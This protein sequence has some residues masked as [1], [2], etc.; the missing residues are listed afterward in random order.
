[1]K[2][3]ISGL[4]LLLSV[5]LVCG[6]HSTIDSL[7]Q[8]L[9]EKRPDSMQVFLLCDLSYALQDSRPD[10]ALLVAQK[11]YFIAKNIN[12]IKGEALGLNQMAAAY[13]SLGDFPKSLEYYIAQLKLEEK[14]GHPVRLTNVYMA[15][16]SLYANSME[17]DKALLYAKKADQIIQVNNFE[18]Y[19]LYSLLNIG[20]VYE[21]KNLLDSAILYTHQSY[22]LAVKAGNALI[23]GTALNNLGNIY[24][25]SG[26]D[27][28]ALQNYRA[29]MYYQTSSGNYSTYAESTL[30]IARIYK[31]Q[32][33]LDSAIY[34]ARKSF[35]IAYSNQFLARAMEASGVLAG[36]YKAADKIDSAFEYQEKMIRLKDAV[37]S[38]DKIRELQSISSAE[39][40]R[41]AELEQ[42]KLA[43]IRE[44]E[45][46]LQFLII[47]IAIPI[48]FLLSIFISRRKVHKRLIE[49]TGIVS[50][51]LFFEFI[52][53]LLHPF[54]AEKSHHS[55]LIEIVIFVAIAAIITPAHHK[56]EHWLLKKLAE[57]N[58]L[59]H[60]LPATIAPKE[61][62]EESPEQA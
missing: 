16:S 33:L 52:T 20:D 30:G 50:V 11:A 2:R 29:G 5:L 46:K 1:M 9:Q 41:Q 62:T 49:F 54:I 35:D 27:T 3:W 39:Q 61:I 7:R 44:R 14:T 43:E 51:L 60:H 47:G 4:P 37:Y 17:F 56:I 32:G 34:Y 18:D 28:A 23:T 31:Q 10:S 15:I 13:K 24:S 36:A 48:F 58:A 57:Y 12:F 6:Q 45:I 25:K 38:Q 59:K 55:P 26:N 22:D 53:L 8:A 19:A 42:L 40:L 21:K